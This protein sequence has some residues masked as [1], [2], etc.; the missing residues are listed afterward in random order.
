MKT[1]NNKLIFKKDSV[2]ELNETQLVNIDGGS[3]PACVTVVIAFVAS[4]NFS[5]NVSKDQN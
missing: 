5:Y 2:L 3:T 1:Q 4:L